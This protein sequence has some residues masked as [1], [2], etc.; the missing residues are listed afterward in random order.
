MDGLSLISYKVNLTNIFGKINFFSFTCSSVIKFKLKI[1]SAVPERVYQ[2][3]LTYNL[4]YALCRFQ[5]YQWGYIQLG[6]NFSCTLVC[7]SSLFAIQV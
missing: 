6:I 5:G 4:P 2:Y 7:G 3:F 1:E